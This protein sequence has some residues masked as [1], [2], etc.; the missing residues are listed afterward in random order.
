MQGEIGFA[1]VALIIVRRSRFGLIRVVLHT[2]ALEDKQ[3]SEE[4]N[5]FEN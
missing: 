2:P 4:R 1:T 5:T 3:L